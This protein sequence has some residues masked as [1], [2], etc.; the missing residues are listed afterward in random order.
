[1][2]AGGGVVS[3]CAGLHWCTEF[4]VEVHPRLEADGARSGLVP[5]N[6]AS[7]RR[8]GHQDVVSTTTIRVD[9]ETHR[10]LVAISRASNRPLIEVLRDAA[11][12]LVRARFATLVAAQLDALR[13]DPDDWACYTAQSEFA[14]H[15]GFA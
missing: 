6:A 8:D 1:M 3:G 14:V 4:G 5:V 11:E 10:R 7:S 12:A 9:H 2:L 13:H 15:D